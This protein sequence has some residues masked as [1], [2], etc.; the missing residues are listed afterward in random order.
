MRAKYGFSLPL[1]YN[2][3][4]ATSIV[5]NAA[6]SEVWEALTD[7]ELIMQYNADTKV[8]TEWKVGSPIRWEGTLG[9]YLYV[10]KGIVLTFVPEELLEYTYWSSI[11]RLQDSPENYQK[12]S[13]KLE[14]DGRGTKVTITI[15]DNNPSYETRKHIEWGWTMVA[16]NLKNFVEKR[17]RALP[18]D[19]ELDRLNSIVLKRDLLQ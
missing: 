6:P 2:Y 1:N 10:N 15:G 16:N 9:L 13:Y 4:F 7:P 18:V 11:S 5:I 12:V 17:R 19:P 14:E 3:S 8:T